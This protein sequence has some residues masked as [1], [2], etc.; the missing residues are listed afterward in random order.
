MFLKVELLPAML[1]SMLLN[2]CVSG[3]RVREH[4]VFLGHGVLVEHA[5]VKGQ[6]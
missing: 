3:G 2:S 4:A 1:L 5:Y 6:G